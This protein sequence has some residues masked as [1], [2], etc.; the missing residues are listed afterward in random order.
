M[1]SWLELK[2]SYSTFFPPSLISCFL[3]AS[4]TLHV[5]GLGFSHLLFHAVVHFNFLPSIHLRHACSDDIRKNKAR[6]IDRK[7][8][9]CAG[10][11]TL[12]EHFTG[13]ESASVEHG[14][15]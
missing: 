1:K 12:A 6:V 4:P 8:H 11:N 10:G 3:S 9:A 5:S 14:S 7:L 15:A 13:E 2:K